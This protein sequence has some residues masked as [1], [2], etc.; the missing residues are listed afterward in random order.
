M[1]SLVIPILCLWATVAAAAP[2]HV[3]LI[4]IDGGAAFH[5]DNPDLELPNIR[6]LIKE[7]VWAESSETVFPSV[8]HPSHTTI[9]TGALPLRHGVL[10]NELPER[11]SARMRTGNSMTRSEV[12]LTKTIFDA[13]KAKGL[14]TAS[15]QWPETVE[16]P[17]IDH[18]LV[19]RTAAGTP[20]G[21]AI[22]PN[23]LTEELRRDGIP[24]DAYEL[25]RQEEGLGM[26]ADTLTTLAACHV[27]R[28]HK[29]NLIAVHIVN[30]DHEQHRYGFN[31]P[32][33]QASLNKADY[34]VGQIV[35]AVEEAGIFDQTVFI[36]AADHGFTSVYDDINLRPFFAEAGLEQK[37]RFYEG[38]WAPFIRLL[39][40]FDAQKDQARLEQVFDRLRQNLHV[41]R[42]Y[43]SEEF[44]AA[45]GLPRYEDSDRVRGQYLI[46]GDAETY[47][48]WAPD[49]STERRKRVRPAHG[50]G[51]LPFHPRMHPLLVMAGNGLK[52][53][54]RIGHVRNVDIAPT[55]LR[56]LGLPAMETDGRELKEAL[57][58]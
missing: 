50:H 58:E 56:L 55:I 31:H 18:N 12:I 8:T 20:R 49:N 19:S 35:R 4:S 29:P 41:L 25:L 28:K 9:I 48:V 21:R 17:A 15:F 6:R 2:R 39:P 11:E 47:F 13:A 32:I 30:P 14:V 34:H 40:E 5:L 43:R 37:V 46:I 16:D 57:A 52:K 26:V 36:I 10:A 33:A 45:V 54:A 27:I 44:P 22:V 38:G 1:R 42:I 51:Y 3:V 53:G 24:I 7:G 23:K